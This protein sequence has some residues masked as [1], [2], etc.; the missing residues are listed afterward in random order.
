MDSEHRRAWLDLPT[1]KRCAIRG[2]LER[3]RGLR[4]ADVELGRLAD[5]LE[6]QHRGA[7]RVFTCYGRLSERERAL[8]KVNNEYQ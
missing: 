3:F 4:V 1:R 6:R 8:R 5:E 7:R 2:D